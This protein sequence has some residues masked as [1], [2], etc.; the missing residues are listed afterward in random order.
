MELQPVLLKAL[1]EVPRKISQTFILLPGAHHLK[2]RAI[3]YMA[4]KS[5]ILK[6][7]LRDAFLMNIMI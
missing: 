5:N 2:P 6:I 4:K 1:E 3:F 7:K